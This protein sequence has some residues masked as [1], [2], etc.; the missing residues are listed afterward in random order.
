MPYETGPVPDYAPHLG[1]CWIWTG[2]ISPEG[3]AS[4]RSRRGLYEKLVGPI[5]VGLDLDHL[6]R[7]RA[8][9]NP[10][11]LEPVSRR[12]NVMRS[13]SF[14]AANAKK[15][16]CDKGHPLKGD[17]LIVGTTKRRGKIVERRRCKTCNRLEGAAFRQRNPGYFKPYNDAAQRRRAQARSAA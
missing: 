11:H 9:V 3:Y 5:P 15:T 4:T 14:A 10:S 8:C 6:C 12:E 2:Y 1:P 13:T 7:V 16:H 17:N